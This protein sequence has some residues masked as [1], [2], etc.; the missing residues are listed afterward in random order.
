[1]GERPHNKTLDRIDNDKGYSKENCRWATHKEQL[2]NTRR[3]TYA[4]VDGEKMPFAVACE[5]FN[6]GI[7]CAR[8]RR[9]KGFTDEQIFKTPVKSLS[10]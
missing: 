4:T 1:M 5:K 10:K 2:N 7:S 9:K 8:H 6:I 3:T